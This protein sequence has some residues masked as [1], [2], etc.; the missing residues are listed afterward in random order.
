MNP[1]PEPPFNAKHLAWLKEHRALLAAMSQAQIDAVAYITYG[2]AGGWTVEN[3][4]K[5]YD[6]HI[7]YYQ[8]LVDQEDRMASL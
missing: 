2:I 3:T 1:P 5:L 4:L 7:A 8:G 6:E